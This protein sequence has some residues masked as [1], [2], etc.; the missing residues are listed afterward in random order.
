MLKRTVRTGLA[1]AGATLL[2]A[3]VVEQMVT[4]GPNYQAPVVQV[5]PP[6]NLPAVCYDPADLGTMHAR[7]VQQQFAT[8]VLGCKSTDGVRIYNQQ[9]S[10]FVAKFRGDL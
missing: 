5:A 6:A 4:E 3:C 2:A 7:M 9:Y 10:D 8:G 1:L